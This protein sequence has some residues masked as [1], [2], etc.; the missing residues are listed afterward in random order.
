MNE[1]DLKNDSNNTA[2]ESN[3]KSTT[4][5]FQDKAEAVE[6]LSLMSFFVLTPPDSECSR[7]NVNF[8]ASVLG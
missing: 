6:L 4:K 3:F 8:G 5:M 7:D 1:V 2:Y